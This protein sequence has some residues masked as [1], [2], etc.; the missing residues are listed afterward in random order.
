MTHHLI[1]FKQLIRTRC[2]LMFEGN[3]EANLQQVLNER[4]S[5]LALEPASYYERLQSS[6]A[7][8]QELVNRLTINETYFF[9]ES[10]QIH[11]LVDHLVPRFLARR[12]GKAALRILS[13][14][15]SSGEEPYSL[16]MALMEKYGERSATLFD[17]HGADIDSTAL[18]KA[19]NARYTRFSFRG[20]S[21]EVQNRYFDKE[22]WGRVLKDSV[23][24]QVSFHPLN[25]LADSL[26]PQLSDFDIVFFRNVSI[27]FDAPTR[28]RVQ[29]KLASMM[30]AQGVLVMGAAETLANDLGVLPLVEEAGQFYFVKGDSSLT[31]QNPQTVMPHRAPP[32]LPLQQ[33]VSE[34]E[35][36]P[37]QPSSP[38][39]VAEVLQA[40]FSDF[41]TLY[42]LVRDKQYEQAL[43]LL[44]GVLTQMTDSTWARLLKA[45]VLIN[46]KEFSAAEHL[47]QEVLAADAWSIDALLLLGLAAKWQQQT[48]VALRW[49]KQATYTRHE[50]WPAQYYLADLYRRGGESELAQ[51]AYRV[52]IQLLSGKEPDTGIQFLPLDLPIGQVRFLCEHQLSKLPAGKALERQR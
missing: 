25:L 12:E 39:A 35:R 50:C 41:E 20:V 32:V 8:F 5:L 23:R 16:V 6:V 44:D 49:F 52:V 7:E 19:R 1:R 4:V 15:C 27:Y 47:A 10:E 51:R 17:I 36:V 38:P 48:E 3:N 21:D 29:D 45:E 24:K 22:D 46:R 18:A 30:K 9:R 33:P 40:P 34:P 14:G 31:A 2:G 28:L 42:G 37:V 26:S 43:P 11:L 13:A